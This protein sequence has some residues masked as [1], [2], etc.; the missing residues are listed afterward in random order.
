MPNRSRH[1][2]WAVFCRSSIDRRASLLPRVLLLLAVFLLP[3]QMRAGANDPHP[4][5]LLQVLLDAR[6]GAIDHHADESHVAASHAEHDVGHPAPRAY[7]PDVPT[8]EEPA[9]AASGGQMLAALVVLVFAPLP[10]LRQVWPAP[11]AR[12]GRTP[13]FDPPPPRG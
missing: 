8:F 2:Q 10:A 13:P 11:P 6:D 1:R 9:P 12:I 4:H 7:D 3:V 5:A